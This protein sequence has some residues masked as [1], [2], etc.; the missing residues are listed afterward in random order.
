MKK[1]TIKFTIQ[2]PEYIEC[3]ACGKE[4]VENIYKVFG[5]SKCQ[6]VGINQPYL[7]EKYLIQSIR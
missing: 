2:E 7:Y 3:E 6:S 5:C 4:C 1:K